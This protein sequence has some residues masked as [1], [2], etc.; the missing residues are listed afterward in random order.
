[1]LRKRENDYVFCYDQLEPILSPL[2][3]NSTY[4]FALL[5]W[6]AY[7]KN[8]ITKTIIL[9]G[10]VISLFLSEKMKLFYFVAINF[11]I[12]I[13]LGQRNDKRL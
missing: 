8:W 2:D 11:I 4:V 3:Y 9:K 12:K 1:M 5:I 13:V 7:N 10:L 6:E